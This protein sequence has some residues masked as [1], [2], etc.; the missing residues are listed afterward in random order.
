M[1]DATENLVRPQ[2][3]EHLEHDDVPLSNLDEPRP[4]RE[5]QTNV[6]LLRNHDLTLG[7]RRRG[8]RV[9]HGTS[10]LLLAR[11]ENDRRAARIVP[12]S[13]RPTRPTEAWA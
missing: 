5:T 1:A 8:R 9:A 10:K 11:S 2:G 7:R 12:A 3:L 13:S 6:N 4:R